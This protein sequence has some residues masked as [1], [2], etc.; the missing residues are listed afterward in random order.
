MKITSRLVIAGMGMAE[1]DEAGPSWGDVEQLW[2]G[3]VTTLVRTGPEEHVRSLKWVVIVGSI[4]AGLLLLALLSAIL[5]A[6]SVAK[7]RSFRLWITTLVCWIIF[8]PRSKRTNTYF[9]SFPSCSWASSRGSGL[10]TSRTPSPSTA[11]A[12]TATASR[13]GRR[14][15]GE[16]PRQK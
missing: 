6:V 10:R 14:P 8:P 15:R 3:T 11:T 4:L 9:S 13:E 7:T 5:W 1:E 12:S 16:E 2:A